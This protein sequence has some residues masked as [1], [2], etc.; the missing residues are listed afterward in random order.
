MIKQSKSVFITVII[1]L[2]FHSSGLALTDE[3]I[4]SQ[5]QFNFLTPGARAT[6]LGGAFIG[7]ADDAT[8]V[9]SNPAGLTQL[10]DPEVSIEF[11]YIAYTADQ[12]YENY[13]PAT[14]LTRREFVD[15]VGS[16]PFVSAVF[17]YNWFVFSLYRQE[18]VNYE[19]TFQTSQA[20]IWIPNTTYWFYPIIA[21]TELTVT[22]YGIGAAI[23]FPFLEGLSLAVSPRW[24]EMKIEASSYRYNGDIESTWD[25]VEGTDFREDEIQ[26][27]TAIDDTAGDISLNFGLMWRLQWF[28]EKLQFPRVSVGAVYRK[29]PKFEVTETLTYDLLPD[30]EDY[31]N[32]KDLATF[33]LK[34][35]DS[36]GVGL[37]IRPRDNL[38]FTL[39]VVR[40]EYE[41]LLEDFD[42]IIGGIPKANFT[43]DNAT[44]IHFGMEYTLEIGKR[45]LA[46]RAGAYTDPDH[47][48]RFSGTT[49]YAIID[50][51]GENRFPGS[52]DQIHITGGVG[53]VVS[54]KFQID[55]AANIAD[56]NKQLSVSAVYRF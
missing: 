55:T 33:T 30:P 15:S 5:F 8:A 27:W 2:C 14:S 21:S 7:L 53:L 4:F 39:D 25:V 52:D 40:I 45:L 17:P 3:E 43:V 13:S 41:D 22:N 46:L 51:I 37:V 34:V 1:V 28:E 54:E 38:T 9:E 10:Y 35:P 23:Q 19:S 50:I 12:M 44:E 20:P 31:V 36:Y 11:K 18:L 56:N 6:A 47:A 32:L 48:I 49:E 26:N 16:I 29:G 42:L 24:S